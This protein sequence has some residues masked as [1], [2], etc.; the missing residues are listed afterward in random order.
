M[1]MTAYLVAF[2]LSQEFIRKIMAADARSAHESF[3][4][5]VLD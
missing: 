1:G 4:L 2:V 5:P 3:Y